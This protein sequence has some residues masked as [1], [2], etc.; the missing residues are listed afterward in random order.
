[1]CPYVATYPDNCIQDE[2]DMWALDRMPGEVCS[3][4]LTDQYRDLLVGWGHKQDGFL[5]KDGGAQDQPAYWIQAFEIIDGQ[6]AL[7]H[8]ERQDEAKAPE[9]N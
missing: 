7:I 1:M 2:P 4:L 9:N 6:L 3:V 8:Q 5:P